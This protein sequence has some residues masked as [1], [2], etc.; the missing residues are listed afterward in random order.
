[1]GFKDL[2]KPRSKPS[3]PRKGNPAPADRRIDPQKDAADRQWER[4][5]EKRGD[6]VFPTPRLACL[7]RASAGCARRF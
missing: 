3:S 7:A 4:E 1:M 5:K 6:F 2:F